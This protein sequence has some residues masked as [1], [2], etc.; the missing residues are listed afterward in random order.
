MNCKF[1]SGACIKKGKYNQVQKYQ[2]KLCKK[3]QQLVYRYRKYD[4][5][6][7][8]QIRVLQ[9]EGLGIS[10][11]GRVLQIPKASVQRLIT[12]SAAKITA[13]IYNEQFQEYEVDELHTFIGKKHFSCYT[14]IIYAI[15]KATR[16]IID[17]V[18]GPRNKMNVGNLIEKLLALSPKRIYTDK[19]ITYSSL[20]PPDIHRTFR[21]R[22]NR[23]ERKNLTLRTHLKRLS[24]KTICFS[25]SICMLEASLRLYVWGSV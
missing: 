6:I 8:T 22:T 15:N 13:P 21:Y 16:R 7:E 23:I 19:L 2:C 4:I 20:I 10:S 24:R 9:N 11:I 3:Y 17:F 1:C 5:K 25:R 18:I 14:Y 12:K